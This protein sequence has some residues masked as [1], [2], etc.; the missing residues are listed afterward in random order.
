MTGILKR[1][2][3]L[4]TERH[5]ER[6]NDVDTPRKRTAIRRQRQKLELCC[7]KPRITWSYQRLKVARKGLT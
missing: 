5:T 7:H 1:G 4:D 2:E 3:S 6:G